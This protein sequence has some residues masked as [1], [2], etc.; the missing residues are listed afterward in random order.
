MCSEVKES[1]VLCSE[2]EW[3][4]IVRLVCDLLL[5]LLMA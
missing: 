5:L 1:L 3:V 4:S 2:M